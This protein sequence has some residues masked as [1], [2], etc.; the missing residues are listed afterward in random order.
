MVNIKFRPIFRVQNFIFDEFVQLDTLD[1]IILIDFNALR[2]VSVRLKRY[3]MMATNY[4][5]VVKMFS[6]KLQRLN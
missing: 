2:L 5:N 4:E 1:L 3:G 6:F